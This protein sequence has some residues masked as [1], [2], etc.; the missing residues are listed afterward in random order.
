MQLRRVKESDSL[1]IT[2]NSMNSV[3][4]SNPSLCYL[5]YEKLGQATA[6]NS[7]EEFSWLAT[8]LCC[9]LINEMC[10]LG[11]TS[12]AKVFHLG[13]GESDDSIDC[14]PNRGVG[15]LGEWS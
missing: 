3:A 10:V 12:S 1:R 14:C 6:W 7:L 4:G 11:T 13:E 5:Q 15:T 8:N 2:M 9:I